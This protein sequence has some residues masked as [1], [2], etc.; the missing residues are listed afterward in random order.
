MAT[1]GAISKGTVSERKRIRAPGRAWLNFCRSEIGKKLIEI[2]HISSH[3]G[4]LTPEQKGNDAADA[5]ANKYRL[6]GE[7]IGPVPYLVS[8][9]E[10]LILEF[11]KSVIQGDPRS[12]LKQMAKK[13]MAEIWRTKTRQGEWFTKYPTQVLKQAKHVWKWSTECGIGRA[14]LFYIFGICQW[15]P[16]NY[17]INY[18]NSDETKKCSLCLSGVPETLDHLLRC[19]ALVEMHILCKQTIKSKFDFWGIPYHNLS[20][21][22]R[23]QGL[24]NKW[25]AATREISTSP[26]LSSARLD[27]LTNGFWKMNQSKQF[28]STR[29]F[30][31][32]FSKI[33]D[34]R[35][36]SLF[37]STTPRQDFLNTLIH[38][39][40]I[41]MHGL[42]DSLHVSPLFEEWS[43]VC[44]EDVPFGA[45]LWSDVNLHQGS[46][47][48]FFHGPDD[49][50]NTKGLLEV[51]AESLVT[52]L[53]TRYV[54]LVPSQ[55]KLPSNFLELAII[56]PGA[57]LYGCNGSEGCLS[58][59]PMSIILAAN[60]ES[61]QV[62]PI[63]WEKFLGKCYQ[64]LNGEF[65]TINHITDS[66]FRE[67]ITLQHSPRTL[68]KQSENT[69]LKSCSIINFYDAYAP[70][71]K[72]LN[73]G[74]IPPNAAKLITQMNR[75]PRFLSLLGILPNQLRTLLKESDYENREE[76]LLD[77]S[78]TLFFAGF[79]IWDQ[80]RKMTSRYWKDIAPENRNIILVK[81]KKKSKREKED[82]IAV[83][84]CTNPFHFLKRYRNL[85]NKRRTRCPCSLPHFEPTHMPNLSMPMF[86]P[87]LEIKQYSEFDFIP[88]RS[89]KIRAQ[90]DRGKK[91]KKT[92]THKMNPQQ[93]KMKKKLK[94]G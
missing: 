56:H 90:H 89:D 13:K 19:P 28:I 12:F 11:Q 40:S 67:R 44:P 1:I 64:C 76:I 17:R 71:E 62:D 7:S 61:L 29:N 54:C 16:T 21:I 46:N 15:L 87:S 37:N 18:H 9:E 86:R 20:F 75:H 5:L 34:S 3:T 78:R 39:F 47:V 73:I 51:L 36:L 43:S 50:I 2:E 79:R 91:R 49:R 26:T 10:P 69:I 25:K 33:L 72:S 59:C 38:E 80:R 14:W 60:K 57:P 52:K 83:S 82:Y 70:T 6:L 41:Q 55:E 22:S 48:F 23:E 8:T 45:K 84:Q 74:S 66:L 27:I 93:R 88:T 31:E 53:P 68:S 65:I 30:L 77:L 92:T 85:S 35:E 58:T 4:S 94:F 63:N 81:K 42:T 32:S 24:R